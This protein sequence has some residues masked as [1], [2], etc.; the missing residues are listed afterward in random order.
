[1]RRVRQPILRIALQANDEVDEAITLLVE[2]GRVI[3]VSRSCRRPPAL[4]APC[5]FAALLIEESLLLM[6]FG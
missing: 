3:S 2:Q 1:M 5:N 6:N 4:G